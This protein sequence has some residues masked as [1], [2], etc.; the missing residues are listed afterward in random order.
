MGP[1]GGVAEE[2][3]SAL[4]LRLRRGWEKVKASVVGSTTSHREDSVLICLSIG[5]IHRPLHFIYLIAYYVSIHP[6]IHPPIHPPIY[7]FTI[8]SSTH[9]S[10]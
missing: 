5:L 1:G 9:Y 3:T 6:S 8:L 7:S 4:C 10:S 2:P